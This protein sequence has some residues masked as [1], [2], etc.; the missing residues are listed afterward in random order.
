MTEDPIAKYWRVTRTL[1]QHWLDAVADPRWAWAALRWWLQDAETRKRTSRPLSSSEEAAEHRAM[2]L[3]R[4]R[5]MDDMVIQNLARI[6]A[7]SRRSEQLL[8]KAYERQ[9]VL[10]R[11]ARERANWHDSMRCPAH[12][13]EPSG[14]RCRHMLGHDTVTQGPTP[15]YDGITTWR[16]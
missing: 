4:Q 16:T 5:E 15:H 10:G 1:M 2:R 11:A 7:Q 9:E 12:S 3:N 13:P 14:A 6:Q 8:K